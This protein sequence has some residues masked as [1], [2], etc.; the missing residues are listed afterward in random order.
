MGV[1]EAFEKKKVT[2][3]PKLYLTPGYSGQAIDPSRD[4]LP[5]RVWSA[6]NSHVGY[7]QHELVSPQLSLVLATSRPPNT[8]NPSLHLP[9]EGLDLGQRL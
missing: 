3:G 5:A 7:S 4:I 1:T 2:S 9:S 8:A 6:Q